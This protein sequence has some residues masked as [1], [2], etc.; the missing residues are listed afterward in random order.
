ML[1]G[2]MMFWVMFVDTIGLPMLPLWQK[3]PWWISLPF[4]VL[5]Q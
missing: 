2:R 3:D 4:K 5:M 1:C